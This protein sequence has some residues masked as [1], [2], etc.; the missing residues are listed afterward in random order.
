LTRGKLYIK[1]RNETLKININ[2][3]SWKA[4]RAHCGHDERVFSFLKIY[5]PSLERIQAY[6]EGLPGDL[7]PSVTCW[8]READDIPESN[9]EVKNYWR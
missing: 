1:I 2:I 9:C 5:R 3:N 8:G 6:I 4:G 7:S